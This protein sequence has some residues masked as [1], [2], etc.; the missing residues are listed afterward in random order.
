[1]VEKGQGHLRTEIYMNI[2]VGQQE[3]REVGGTVLVVL[4]LEWVI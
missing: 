3:V 1:M 2:L 4:A